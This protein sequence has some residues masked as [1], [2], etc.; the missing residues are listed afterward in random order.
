MADDYWEG[1]PYN[2]DED[3]CGHAQG[4]PSTARVP[5]AG[6]DQTERLRVREL[7]RW[8][9]LSERSDRPWRLLAGKAAGALEI[10][11]PHVTPK[12]L[13]SHSCDSAA[14]E[15]PCIPRWCRSGTTTMTSPL[16]VTPTMQRAAVDSLS[17]VIG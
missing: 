8:D 7:R 4:I 2:D 6:A 11:V 5:V 15:R 14:E 13:A 16:H 17:S 10:A 9:A 3:G 12:G 1:C